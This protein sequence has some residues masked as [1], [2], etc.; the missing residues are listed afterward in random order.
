MTPPTLG[1]KALPLSSQG[2]PISISKT[3]LVYSP[4]P[5]LRKL[6]IHIPTRYLPLI[7]SEWREK[8]SPCNSPSLFS[9]SWWLWPSE[10]SILPITTN[11]TTVEPHAPTSCRMAVTERIT[12]TPTM[13]KCPEPIRLHQSHDEAS[14]HRHQNSWLHHHQLA[15]Q[16]TPT[17]IPTATTTPICVR[18]PLLTWRRSSTTCSTPAEASSGW[19]CR[20]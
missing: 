13:T 5:G 7:T 8:G 9:H 6:L 10:T 18:C 16:P 17:P 2:R 14:Q 3:T 11:S 20:G 19:L 1:A 15:T 12:A 4:H